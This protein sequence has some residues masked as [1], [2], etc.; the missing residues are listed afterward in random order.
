MKITKTDFNLKINNS[1]SFKVY[2]CKNR[3][4]AFEIMH[5]AM[6]MIPT[7]GDWY[8]HAGCNEII[9]DCRVPPFFH[10]MGLWVAV[11]EHNNGSWDSEPKYELYIVE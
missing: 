8:A 1:S 6:T 2:V 4:H 9:K 11:V 10:N 5:L 3:E 7:G